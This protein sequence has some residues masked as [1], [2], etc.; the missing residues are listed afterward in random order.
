MDSTG[1]DWFYGPSQPGTPIYFYQQGLA[2]RPMFRGN[3]W[4]LPVWDTS[5]PLWL[6]SSEAEQHRILFFI[7]FFSRN[8][9]GDC[10]FTWWLNNL[11]GKPIY[12]P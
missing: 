6:R 2:L 1:L 4:M 8:I 10:W 9:D 3:P 12:L 5:T 11:P 7:L